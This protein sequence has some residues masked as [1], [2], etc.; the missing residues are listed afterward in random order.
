MEINC[1]KIKI[2][3]LKI[4]KTIKR[5]EIDNLIGHLT[6]YGPYNLLAGLLSLQSV[7]FKTIAIR[8]CLF[9]TSLNILDIMEE[10]EEEN[11]TFDQYKT[12]LSADCASKWGFDVLNE[13]TKLQLIDKLPSNFL[14]S[15]DFNVNRMDPDTFLTFL[16]GAF[17]SENR[18][19]IIWYRWTSKLGYN[20]A[21]FYYNNEI[22]DNS[23]NLWQIINFRNFANIRDEE[24]MGRI[25]LIN[26]IGL[27]DK[28]LKFY[29]LNDLI[30]RF[31][32]LLSFIK[33]SKINVSLR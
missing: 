31:Y 4:L 33:L 6:I 20:E 8:K 28:S 16:N 23:K 17:N 13:L 19:K 27:K 29:S 1:L 10:Y 24:I 15:K 2:E 21:K 11:L 26:F 14:E 32:T 9:M 30:L 5:V 18:E 22:W 7:D 12:I 25:H 3:S